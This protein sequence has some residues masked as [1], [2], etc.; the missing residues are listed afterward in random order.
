M[1]KKIKEL[2]LFLIYEVAAVK[3]KLEVAFLLGYLFL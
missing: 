3:T 1:K 2:I